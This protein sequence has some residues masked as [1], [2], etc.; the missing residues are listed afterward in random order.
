MKLYLNATSPFARF[1]RIV[2]LEKNI[3]GL[4]LVWCDPWQ[5]DAE[6]LAVNP[7]GRIPALTH[8]NIA[9]TESVLIALYLDQLSAPFL[10]STQEYALQLHQ[11]GLGMGLMEAAFNLV[12]ARKYQ[13]KSPLDARRDQA[14]KRTLKTLATEPIALESLAGICLGVALDY[15]AFRLPE[16]ELPQALQV[17][18]QQARGKASFI[19]TAFF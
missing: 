12:I 11:L 17:L 16:Y 6:L 5:D 19:Q 9:L 14:I 2:A 13:I 8:E 15:L 3:S 1:A 10:L 4:E 7:L 18:Q